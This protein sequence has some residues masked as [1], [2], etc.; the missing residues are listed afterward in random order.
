MRQTPKV[1]VSSI[2]DY[3]ALGGGDQGLVTTVLKA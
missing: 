1:M 2:L 3:K